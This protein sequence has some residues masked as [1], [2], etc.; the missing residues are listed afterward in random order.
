MCLYLDT[1]EETSI[2]ELISFFFRIVFYGLHARS[3]LMHI[4]AVTLFSNSRD[5]L[6]AR[7]ALMHIGA[8]THFIRTAPTTLAVDLFGWCFNFY[9]VILPK[10]QVSFRC[11][12]SFWFVTALGL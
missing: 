3:A 8:V 12:V 11:F 9:F 1:F 7:F 10:F 4:A 2:P 5:G 6:H